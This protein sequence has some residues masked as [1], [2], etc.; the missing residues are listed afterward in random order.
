MNFTEILNSL[1]TALTSYQNSLHE[2]FRELHTLVEGHLSAR[3]NPHRL[4]KEDISLGRV[5]NYP[6]ATKTQALS[7]ESNNAYMTPLR[8]T[9][10]ID[11]RLQS[12]VQSQLD[13]HLMELAQVFDDASDMLE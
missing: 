5:A 2:R 4:T 9:Q 11:A 3:G 13:E 7:G 1:V 12:G 10:A 8:T 6:P